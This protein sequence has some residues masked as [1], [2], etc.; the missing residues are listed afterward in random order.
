MDQSVE[1]KTE[2]KGRIISF[3][4]A[5]KLKIFI[6]I[7]ILVVAALSFVFYKFNNEKKNNLVAEKYI[8]AGLNLAA[9][10]KDFATSLYKEII[11]SNNKFYS[12]LS[13][14]TVIEKNL[15]S[16][17]DKILEYFDILKNSIKTKNQQDLITLKKAL[18]LLKISDIEESNQ[19]LNDLINKDS[20]LEPIVEELLKK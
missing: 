2:I 18:Y 10:K 16:D 20:I 19:L 12:I 17:K 9:N 15:I 1:N 13:L 14:N 11:L 5:N 6:F 8:E 3:Y 4:N 7:S